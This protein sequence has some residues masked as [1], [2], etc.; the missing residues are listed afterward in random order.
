MTS[1]VSSKSSSQSEVKPTENKVQY[2]G[3]YED[4]KFWNKAK[5]IELSKQLLRNQ[6]LEKLISKSK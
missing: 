3:K 2:N 6:G 4:Q 1:R 5:S